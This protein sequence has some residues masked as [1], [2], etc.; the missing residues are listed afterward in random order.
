MDKVRALPEDAFALICL[1]AA[2]TLMMSV[3]VAVPVPVVLVALRVT[4]EVAAVLGV[5]EIKPVVV[6]TDK[7]AGN[8]MAPKLVGVLEAVI[9]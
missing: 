7:P 1:K 8:P 3:S 5:P 2:G 9:W 6:L 4:V